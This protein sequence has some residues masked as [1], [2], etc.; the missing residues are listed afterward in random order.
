MSIRLIDLNA[1][2]VELNKNKIEYR[3]DIDEVLRGMPIIDPKDLL[4]RG[5]NATECH[6]SDEFVCSECGLV[7]RDHVRYD[8]EDGDED[9]VYEYNPKFCPECGAKMGRRFDD[10]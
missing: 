10:V 3:A 8:P 6:P 7:L 4:E 9:I 2:I 5:Y 1:L